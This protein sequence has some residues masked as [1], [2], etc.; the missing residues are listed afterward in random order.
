VL[1]GTMSRGLCGLVCP[2]RTS[3][4]GGEGDCVKEGF[5]FVSVRTIKKH[6]HQEGEGKGS[7]RGSVHWGCDYATALGVCQVL[8]RRGRYGLGGG[9][10]SFHSGIEFG[11]SRT[12]AGSSG[13]GKKGG[14]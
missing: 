6:H 8:V 3:E 13:G 5:A 2:S 9:G 12:G 7:A 4:R 11:R 14:V 10:S 1:R